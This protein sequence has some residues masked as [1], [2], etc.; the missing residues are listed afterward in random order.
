LAPPADFYPHLVAM[1]MVYCGPR[2]ISYRDL[3]TG[4]AIV[5]G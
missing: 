4:A 1:A 5:H 3:G 2:Q